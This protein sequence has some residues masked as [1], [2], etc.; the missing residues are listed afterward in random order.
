MIL[1]CANNSTWYLQPLQIELVCWAV[2]TSSPIDEE[3]NWRELPLRPFNLSQ[4]LLLS[5]S[6]LSVALLSS[7]HVLV[8]CKS[9]SRELPAILVDKCDSVATFQQKA[10]QAGLKPARTWLC[11]GAVMDAALPVESYSQGS[12]CECELAYFPNKIVRVEDLDGRSALLISP[13][14]VYIDE[15]HKRIT[16]ISG[17]WAEIVAF[18]TNRQI[19]SVSSQAIF[20]VFEFCPVLLFAYG[21]FYARVASVSTLTETDIFLRSQQRRGKDLKSA[22]S[23]SAASPQLLFS[24]KL[25]KSFSIGKLGLGNSTDLVLIARN[26]EFDRKEVQCKVHFLLNSPFYLSIFLLTTGQVI[27]E[28]IGNKLHI[29]SYGSFRLFCEGREVLNHYNLRDMGVTGSEVSVNLFILQAE[30]SFIYAKMKI[31]R[32]FIPFINDFTCKSLQKSLQKLTSFTC[33]NIDLYYQGNLLKDGETLPEGTEVEVAFKAPLELLI[34]PCK[35]KMFSISTDPTELI[36]AF[37]GKLAAVLG[38]ALRLR[39]RGKELQNDLRIGDYGLE[40]EDIVIEMCAEFLNIL[41][42]TPS[43]R[44]LL[45]LS[46][47]PKTKVK[48]IVHKLRTV[49]HLWS[50]ELNLVLTKELADED[51]LRPFLSSTDSPTLFLH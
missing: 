19:Y 47:H 35:G 30:W 29:A 39:Y 48:K 31:G 10:I 45:D 5:G 24:G 7:D 11:R 21:D 3:E 33:E 37:K 13:K 17:N 44:P 12:I 14:E 50:C 16:R 36:S 38:P 6:N 34:Q 26:S 51:F 40:S 8:G 2:G 1:P 20:P 28:N 41:V 46:L 4:S 49:L 32:I 27:K 42:K 18:Y 43:G 22:L 25:L 15:F 9:L 23:Q